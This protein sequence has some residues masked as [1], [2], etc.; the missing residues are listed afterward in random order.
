MANINEVYL[1]VGVDTKDF[2][3]SIAGITR[4]IR[5]LKGLV[6]SSLLSKEDSQMVNTRMNTLRDSLQ[7]IKVATSGLEVGDVFGNMAKYGSLAASAV[8]A[9][10][11]GLSL[12]GDNTE[13]VQK[14]QTKLMTAI[15]AAMALQQLSDAKRLKSLTEEYGR[16]VAKALMIKVN[17]A[18]IGM[19]AS[20]VE[21]LTVA[22]ALNLKGVNLLTRAQL[23][24]NAAMSSNPIGVLVVA[25]AALTAA[26]VIL[27]NTFNTGEEEVKSWEKSLDGTV[28]KNKELRDEHDKH[29]E[30]LQ[31]V[32]VEIRKTRGEITDFQADIES[33]D[34]AYNNALTKLQN[35]TAQKLQEA[36]DD[37]TSFWGVIKNGFKQAFGIDVVTEFVQEN[38]NIIADANIKE[39]DLTKKHEADK[40]LIRANAN[41]KRVDDEKATLQRI[42]E[43]NDKAL[44]DLKKAAIELKA[45]IYNLNYEETSEKITKDLEKNFENIFAEF[46]A[47]SEKAF[48]DFKDKVLNIEE[49]IKEAI[50]EVNT[51]GGPESLKSLQSLKKLDEEIK[52]ISNAFVAAGQ[53]FDYTLGFYNIGTVTKE[54]V[55]GYKAYLDEVEKLRDQYYKD[56]KT[57]VG[58]SLGDSIKAESERFAKAVQ[59]ESEK[60]R[61]ETENFVKSEEFILLTKKTQ[62][63]VLEKREA[64]FNNNI[65]TMTV[66]QRKKIEELEKQ[67]QEKL[68]AL[69]KEHVEL[70]NK[71]SE[72]ALK[73]M[74]EINQSS[75][76]QL[77]TQMGTVKQGSEKYNSMLTGRNLLLNKQIE[78]YTQLKTVQESIIKSDV[79]L[80]D[81]EK[82][83]KIAIICE[84][85]EEAIANIKQSI[86]TIPDDMFQ[87]NITKILGYVQ[88]GVQ[89]IADF[90]NTI[91]SAQLEKIQQQ[92]EENV[93]IIED[94]QS[95]AI[96]TLDMI[97]QKGAMS[98]GDYMRE[99]ERIDEEAA[100][101]VK[102]EKEKAAKKEKEYRMWQAVIGGAGAV[103]NGLQ[104]VPFLPLGIIM[105]ALAAVLAGVQIAAIASEPLPTFGTGGLVLGKSHAEGGTLAELEDQEFV[106][107]KSVVQRPGMGDFLNGVNQGKIG[108]GSTSETF[109]EN[110]L[111]KIVTE[112]VAGASTIPVINVET[113]YT[114]V[115]RKVKSIESKAVW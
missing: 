26:I 22:E 50:D 16:L 89:V 19:E 49:R 109:N 84:Q 68:D 110:I 28:I 32:Q 70:R 95:A 59:T 36:G 87:N 75:I 34:I 78:A 33:L 94:Q 67:K 101:K 71:Y 15:S 55:I 38:A 100:A 103:V 72:D 97:Y 2:D 25:I 69:T 73:D 41:K 51:F 98:Y 56:L 92:T 21:G 11:G 8:G 77:D 48:K 80:T 60:Y 12:V 20:A 29:V 83:R 31:L 10:A 61:L 79:S 13:E 44:E 106:V 18:A 7:D 93:A 40:Q 6:G 42:K 96:E 39:T 76:D 52:T 14:L 66:E 63:E 30:A 99:K 47:G 85:I 53:K 104:T 23:A 24:W 9:V 3:S 90:M 45:F 107:Q 27:Y 64:E 82:A 102:S 113:E 114:G 54:G 35:D 5:Q 88:M 111:R 46:S 58:E 65:I 108:P 1:K 105:G 62:Q 86:T 112:V 115:Q 37:F 57:A 4:E 81:E 91:M 43:V 17:T 74:I